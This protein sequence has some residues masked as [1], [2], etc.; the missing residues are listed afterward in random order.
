MPVFATPDFGTGGGIACCV[1]FVWGIALALVIVGIVRGARLLKTGVPQD[2]KRGILL[3]LV[4]ATLPAF[5]YFGPP[6]FDRVV[7]GNFPIG[8]YEIGK[9][10]IKEGMS[11]EE[12]ESLLG[13][14]HERNDRS[15]GS[16]S[17]YYWIDSFGINWF[18]VQFGT[19]GRVTST[20][21]N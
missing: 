14:P 13:P 16:A 21:G 4:C 15:D 5:C 18:G 17:W 19:D 2:R 3:I 8:S 6:Y 11:K 20:H 9:N 10:K 1:L 12:V 7:Y